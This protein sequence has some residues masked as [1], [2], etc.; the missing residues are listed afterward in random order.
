MCGTP[1][2]WRGARGFQIK[3]YLGCRD[4]ES[5]AITILEVYE[6]GKSPSSQ[7]NATLAEEERESRIPALCPDL[8]AGAN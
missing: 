3:G 8:C 7:K 5:F 6:G 2:S 4:N 1:D